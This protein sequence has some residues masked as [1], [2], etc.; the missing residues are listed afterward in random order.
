[1]DMDELTGG[2]NLTKAMRVTKQPKGTTDD[3]FLTE[4]QNLSCIRL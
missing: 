1:M 3:F 4:S 2:E